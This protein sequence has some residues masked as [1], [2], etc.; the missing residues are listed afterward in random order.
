MER[1]D[2]TSEVQDGFSA[3]KVYGVPRRYDLATLFAV[4]VAYA[5]MFGVMRALSFPL[6]RFAISAAF[7]TSVGIGQAL[8]FKGKS[9]R[10]A[11]VGVGVSLSVATMIKLFVVDLMSI[12][13]IFI[14]FLIEFFKE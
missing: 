4:S 2:R 7:V 5:I 1:S 11:S 8:L 14:H 10:T 3:A 9:P 6:D 12:C 13:I